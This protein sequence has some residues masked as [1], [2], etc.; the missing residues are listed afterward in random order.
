MS[1]RL[2]AIVLISVGLVVSFSGFPFL[3]K[4]LHLD[5]IE[6]VGVIEATEVHLSAKI[7]GRIKAIPFNEGDLVP[8]NAE[9]VRLHM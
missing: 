5:Y 2:F 6:R 1:G 9:V 7:S 8:L 4:P 3:E